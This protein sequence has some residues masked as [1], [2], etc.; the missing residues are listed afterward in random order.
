MIPST[1]FTIPEYSF[2]GLGEEDAIKKYG[3]D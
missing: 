2:C 1:M 3:K